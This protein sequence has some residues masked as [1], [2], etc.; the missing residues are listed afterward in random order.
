MDTWMK[1]A[2]VA[3]AMV[4]AAVAIVMLTTMTS[5]PNQFSHHQR[6]NQRL[7]TEVARVPP[8]QRLRLT[9]LEGGEAGACHLLVVS[10]TWRYCLNRA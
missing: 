2:L 6:L 5:Q 8:L 1:I 7:H 9:H 4:A 10:T 3:L